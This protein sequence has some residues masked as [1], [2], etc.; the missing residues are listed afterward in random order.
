MATAGELIF[1]AKAATDYRHLSGKLRNKKEHRKMLRTKVSAAGKP[2]LD[3]VRTA[4]LELRITGS[5]RGG[6]TARRREYNVARAKTERVA[7]AALKRRAGL[8]RTVASATKLQI[9]AKG[10]RFIV[11]EDKMPP[12]QRGLPRALDLEKGWN[13]PVYG[14]SDRP[15]V[16]QAGGPWFKSTIQKHEQSFRQ[17]I[18]QAME[19][20][21]RDVEG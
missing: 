13:H 10:V 12:E 9:T 15:K 17:A 5:G 14:R 21:K 7:K 3:E 19:E 16:H 20:I 18:V 2:V 6:G 8:R 1:E 4:V 11:D